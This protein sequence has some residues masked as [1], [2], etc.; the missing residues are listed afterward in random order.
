MKSREQVP[1]RHSR[2]ESVDRIHGETPACSRSNGGREFLL[3]LALLAVLGITGCASAAQVQGMTVGLDAGITIPEASTLKNAIYLD[4]VT[5]GKETNPLWNSQVGNMEFESALRESLKAH[6]LLAQDD[7]G[8][9]G[10]TLT[11]ELIDLD[12]PFLAF[13]LTVKSTVFYRLKKAGAD[14]FEKTIV[15]DYTATVS[16]A[17]SGTVRLRLANEGSIRENIKNFIRELL[18]KTK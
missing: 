18:L 4:A 6:R 13:D 10:Y 2:D 15:A 14:F 7:K 8:G 5:G 3:L 9:T 1:R 11:A 16:D 12:Q 17:F